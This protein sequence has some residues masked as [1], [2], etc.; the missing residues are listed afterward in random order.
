[1]T[2][3]C[4]DPRRTCDLCSKPVD[5]PIRWR[6]GPEL[7]ELQC[8]L[9]CFAALANGRRMAREHEAGHGGEATA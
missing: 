4:K 6:P 7:A 3:P 9:S 5:V 2:E 1:M 8:C